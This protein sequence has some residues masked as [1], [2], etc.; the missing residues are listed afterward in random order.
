MLHDVTWR[1]LRACRMCISATKP[2]CMAV[3]TLRAGKHNLPLRRF[4]AP[5]VVQLQ[6]STP[7]EGVAFL[8]APNSP[9]VMLVSLIINTAAR[10]LGVDGTEAQRAAPPQVIGADN[11]CFRTEPEAPGQ[12]GAR[13]SCR[14][15]PGC[16]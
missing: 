7:G 2:I 16:D 10:E 15:D 1:G 14:L 11:H 13:S 3:L 6:L 4:L 9:P 5:F 12:R 8:G